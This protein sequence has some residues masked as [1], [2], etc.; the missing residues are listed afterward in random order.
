MLTAG[1][2]QVCWSV[3]SCRFASLRVAL[4]F[5]V[6]WL[7]FEKLWVTISTGVFAHSALVHTLTQ[8][9]HIHAA[10]LNHTPSPRYTHT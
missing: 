1:V 4:A 3:K 2:T 6:I 7:L 8:G 10:A 9:T 5:I